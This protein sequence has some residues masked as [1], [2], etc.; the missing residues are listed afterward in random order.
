MQTWNLLQQK[1]SS[2]DITNLSRFDTFK[3]VLNIIDVNNLIT[4]NEKLLIAYMMAEKKQSLSESGDSKQ[5]SKYNVN[6]RVRFKP[7]R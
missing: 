5:A 6:G 3:Y 7:F 2:V 1:L 4:K